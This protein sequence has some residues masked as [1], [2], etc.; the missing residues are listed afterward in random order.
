MTI[1]DWM[2]L[3][4][5]TVGIYRWSRILTGRVAILVWRDMFG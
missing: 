2:L 5:F 4:L 3:L 1:P